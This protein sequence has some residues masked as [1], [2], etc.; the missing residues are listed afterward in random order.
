MAHLLGYLEYLMH[1]SNQ[2]LH[3][4]KLVQLEP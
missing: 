2:H 4:V 3:H 1:I